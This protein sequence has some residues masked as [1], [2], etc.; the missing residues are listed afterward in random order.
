MDVPFYFLMVKEIEQVQGTPGT[1]RPVSRQGAVTTEVIQEGV[2]PPRH[3]PEPVVCSSRSWV[4]PAVPDVRPLVAGSWEE[5]EALEGGSEWG[6]RGALGVGRCDSLPA[7]MEGFQPL[8]NGPSVWYLLC[9]PDGGRNNEMPSQPRDKMAR[10]AGPAG[11][12]RGRGG[13]WCQG[14]KREF[15]SRRG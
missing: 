11:Q 8:G 2:V 14:Q 6:G 9:T 10:R 12:V 1:V 3:E 4:L 13:G 5:P 7:G 15:S